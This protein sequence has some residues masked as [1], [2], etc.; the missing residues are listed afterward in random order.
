MLVK[1]ILQDIFYTIKY[2]KNNDPSISFTI[3][4]LLYPI[5]YALIL[6]RISHQMYILRIP[7]IP[8][9]LSQISRFFT[10]IEIHPGAQIGKGLFIDHGAGVV[11][12]QTAIIGD[13]CLLYQGV[14]LGGNGKEI[15]K[16]HPIL[17]NNI[18]V[19]AGAIVLGRI[20]VG[21]NSKI[22]AGSV[23][24]KDIPKF[25]T[26]VGVPGKIIYKNTGQDI[27]QCFHDRLTQ[28][29][30]PDLLQKLQDQLN[31]CQLKIQQLELLTA[32]DN[33]IK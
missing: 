32:T 1:E 8:R 30:Y 22:G 19:G 6:H 24:V 16:R 21:D 18:V 2:I 14:T 7:F 28:L 4:F 17:G 23:I 27:K 33:V 29:E 5:F 12:G 26:V 15:G 25:S 10:S 11:I 13:F 20:T 31:E 9:L 3:E